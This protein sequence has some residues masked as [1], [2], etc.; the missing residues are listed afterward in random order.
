MAE[1]IPFDALIGKVDSGRLQRSSC[2]T[3][4]VIFADV[5]KGM[6]R[7]WVDSSNAENPPYEV[8]IDARARTCRCTC[9]DF[10][11]KAAPCKHLA[12]F[13]RVAKAMTN[14]ISL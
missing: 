10:K 9:E 2:L 5:A 3:T 7:G 8:R 6:F 11:R 4:R 13:A 12:A 14:G 1:V